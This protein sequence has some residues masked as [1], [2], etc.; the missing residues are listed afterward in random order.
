MNIKVFL[1]GCLLFM[2]NN[3]LAADND[4]SSKLLNSP[5]LIPDNRIWYGNDINQFGDVRLPEGAGPFPLVVVS[6]GGYWRS[7]YNLDHISYLCEELRQMGIATWSLEYRRIGNLGGGYPGTFSDI[8]QGVDFVTQL[9]DKINKPAIFD[10]N[11]LVVMGHSAGGHLAV[12]AASR[13]KIAT[14]NILYTKQPLAIKNVIS[15]AGLLD[16]QYAQEHKLSDSAVDE[17]FAGYKPAPLYPSTS[18]IDML[19]IKA[20]VHLV[21]GDE[22]TNVPFE[23]SQRYLEKAQTQGM[24]TSLLTLKGAGHFDIIDPSSAYFIEI[25]NLLQQIVQ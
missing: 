4:M 1:L 10:L 24:N 2:T 15:L 12:W 16:L 11:K 19:P 20:N 5:P 22:D 14:D 13:D 21:H 3:V 8:G 17:L 7:K 9:A 18:P 25:K 6:H 23:I